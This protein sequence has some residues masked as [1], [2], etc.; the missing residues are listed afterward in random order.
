MVERAERRAAEPICVDRSLWCVAPPDTTRPLAVAS[1][2]LLEAE[3]TRRR[4]PEE[5][6]ENEIQENDQQGLCEWRVHR[7]ED[8][9]RRR[10]AKTDSAQRIGRPKRGI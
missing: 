4:P 1:S 6:K 3:N 5:E 8:E 7:F 2:V 9:W 10:L